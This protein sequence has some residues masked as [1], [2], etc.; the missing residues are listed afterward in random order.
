MKLRSTF[1]VTVADYIR[2]GYPL[3]EALTI[4]LGGITDGSGPRTTQV[5]DDL[6]DMGVI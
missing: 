6:K 3:T 2:K 5:L 4:V 1:S